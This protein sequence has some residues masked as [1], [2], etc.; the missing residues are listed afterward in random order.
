MPARKKA[1]ARKRAAK[2]KAPVRRTRSKKQSGPSKSVLVVLLLISLSC[3]AVSVYMLIDEKRKGSDTTEMERKLEEMKRISPDAEIF[4]L[5]EPDPKKKVASPEPARPTPAPAPTRPPAPPKPAPQPEPEPIKIDLN[6]VVR[7]APTA[8]PQPQ[9]PAPPQP[10]RITPPTPPTPPAPEPASVVRKAERVVG[11]APASQLDIAAWQIRLERHHFSMGTIDGDYGMRS[12]RA[13][14]QFQKHHGLPVTGELDFETRYKLGMPGNPFQLYTVTAADMDKIQPPPSTWLEKSK[15]DYLGYHDAWE[16]LAEKFSST[17]GF[18]KKLNPGVSNISAGTTI[19]APQ[20]EP[21]MPLPKID[22][23]KIILPETTLLTYKDGKVMSC[24]PCSI[25]RDK[26]KRPAGR[27]EVKNRAPNPNYTFSPTL[28]AEA[29]Q[30]EGI[31]Q[32]LIIPPGPNNPVG[33]AW[34]GLTLPGY[35][36]HGTTEPT[37][38]SRTGSSGCFRL[39]NWNA[40]KLIHMVTVGVPVEIIE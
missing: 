6:P 20:L 33:S 2:R 1:P 31:E 15:V 12:R 19:T 27:L 25:A 21:A 29:A 14:T 10:Q 38:I 34:I 30:A 8:P 18:L 23:I 4:N 7:V 17:E 22:Q 35:G 39:A 13:V 26:N 3:L 24:F 32:R 37:E 28:F 16:M 5:G 36:I 40:T 9:P 11:P